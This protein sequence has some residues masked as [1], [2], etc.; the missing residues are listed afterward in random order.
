MRSAANL[1]AWGVVAMLAALAFVNGQTLM[2]P[3]P[4]DLLVTQ[5]QAPLGAV[6]LG[7]TAVIVLLFG[8]AALGHRIGTLLELRRLAN[9]LRQARALADKA[10][11]S[12]I[13][14]LQQ[15]IGAEFR[16]LRERLELGSGHLPL[17]PVGIAE[18]SRQRTLMQIITRREHQA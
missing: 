8:L 5:V 13:E 15:F 3:A 11:A 6:L 4:L 7:I 9:E 18:P 17:A 14:A 16:T 2:A 1:L 10:E 12:R